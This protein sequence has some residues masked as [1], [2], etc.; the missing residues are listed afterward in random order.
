MA[1]DIVALRR[2][3]RVELQRYQK[4]HARLSASS[5]VPVDPE[6]EEVSEFVYELQQMHQDLGNK[7][8]RSLPIPAHR[9][10]NPLSN[11]ACSPTA[12]GP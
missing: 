12:T 8:S 5:P 4:A 9:D 2:D 10:R 11:A 6:D 1:G 3:L 7:L